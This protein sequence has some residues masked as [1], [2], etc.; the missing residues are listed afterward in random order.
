VRADCLFF[1]AKKNKQTRKMNF[2]QRDTHGFYVGW[3]NDET[4]TMLV[5]IDTEVNTYFLHVSLLVLFDQCGGLFMHDSLCT[6]LAGDYMCED[7]PKLRVK[8][9]SAGI[10]HKTNK[11]SATVLYLDPG[12]CLI[13]KQF[14]VLFFVFFGCLFLFIF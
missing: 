7:M 10:R 1:V 9:V 12:P 14:L 5:A 8:V 11:L 4:H 3:P 13:Y 6:H 2:L